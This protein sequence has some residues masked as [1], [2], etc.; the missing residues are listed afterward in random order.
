VSGDSPKQAQRDPALGMNAVPSMP[1]AKAPTATTTL[2][3]M[4][5]CQQPKQAPRQDLQRQAQL[6]ALLDAERQRLAAEIHDSVGQYLASALVFLESSQRKKTTTAARRQSYIETGIEILQLAAAES[7][8][9]INGLL[10]PQL[11]ERGLDG[12]MDG[13]IALQS[14]KGG[15]TVELVKQGDIGRLDAAIARSAYRIIQGLL[16]RARYRKARGARVTLGRCD[17]FLNIDVEDWGA[18]AAA[19]AA[20]CDNVELQDVR[21]RVE[22]LGGQ[23]Q[24][25][26]IP[27]RGSCT[28]V[29]LRLD[30]RAG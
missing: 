19:D 23:M 7:R 2:G 27:Q 25:N 5:G 15:F 20:G 14:E 30:E 4:A 22:A 16:S 28:C 8:R 10:P 29:S 1:D 24:T 3:D 21:M 12:A 11:D 6:I 9:L 17:P 13:L 26:A 18:H